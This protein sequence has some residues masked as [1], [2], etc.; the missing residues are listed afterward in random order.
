MKPINLLNYVIKAVWV[1]FA[2]I[3]FI[4]ACVPY[5]IA[6]LFAYLDELTDI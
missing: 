1:T 2:I 3:T 5:G 6:L 4:V